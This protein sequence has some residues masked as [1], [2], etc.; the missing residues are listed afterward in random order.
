M[1]ITEIYGDY[2]MIIKFLLDYEFKLNKSLS[3]ILNR[4]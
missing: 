3:D 4:F 1:L 2:Y